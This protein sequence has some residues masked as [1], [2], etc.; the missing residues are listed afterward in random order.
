MALC[1]KMDVTK[2]TSSCAHMRTIL[3]DTILHT[4]CSSKGYPPLVCSVVRC[5]RVRKSAKECQ[6]VPKG[7]K[8][9]QRVPTS[10]KGCQRLPT[11]A[12]EYHRVP[13]DAKEYQS[14]PPVQPLPGHS[15]PG[16]HQNSG[17]CSETM[18]SQYKGLVHI[19]GLQMF[20]RCYLNLPILV[21]TRTRFWFRGQKCRNTGSPCLDKRVLPRGMHH[22]T[23]VADINQPYRGGGGFCRGTI[24]PRKIL[25]PSAVHLEERLTVSQSVS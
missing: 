17:I 7:V 9:C 2:K 20:H 23:H 25:L 5:Q 24:S 16:A 15:H 18:Q 8:E 1:S 6:R 14:A 13:K 12:K 21:L 22:G 4:G 11:S 10:S 19:P 3:T